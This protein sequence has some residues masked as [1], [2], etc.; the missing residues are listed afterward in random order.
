MHFVVEGFLLSLGV[1]LEFHGER[2]TFDICV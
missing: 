1:L 2:V